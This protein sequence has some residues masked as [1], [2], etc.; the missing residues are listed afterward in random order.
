M[1]QR[2]IEGG[3]K[4]TQEQFDSYKLPSVTT[5]LSD[6][7]GNGEFAN[8]PK[9]VLD[10]ACDRGHA[11][12]ESIEEFIK[13]GCKDKPRIALE[14]QIYIDYFNDWYDKYK[15]E[16]IFSEQKLVSE[17]LGTKG[18]ID[19]L[20]FEGYTNTLVMCDW[21]TSSSLNVFKAKC[22]LNLYLLLLEEAQPSYLE[23]VDKLKILSLTKSGYKYYEF[24]PDRE[25]AKAILKIYKE[26]HAS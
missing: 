7:F 24:K 5:I 10:A 25:L 15:P 2:K 21:K 4:M 14:Y 8:I 18:I 9:H 11:V 23:K 12:H 20:Y 22:Q 13:T 3:R 19:T 6:V 17:K 1:T 16:F 26:K